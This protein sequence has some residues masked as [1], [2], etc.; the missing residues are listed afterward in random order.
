MPQLILTATGPDRPG[1]VGELTGVLHAANCNILESR[2]VNLRGEFAMIILFDCPADRA[3]KIETELE[4]AA[5]KMGLRA[6]LS[7]QHAQAARISGQTYRLKTYSTD[8]PG[9][10]ARVTNVLR[11]H[12]VNIEELEAKQESAPFAGEP[13]FLTEMV[14]TFPAATDVANLRRDLTETGRAIHCDIDL[15][16]A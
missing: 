15:D 16:P 8:Q 10:V 4:G 14:L 13:L 7:A 12:G 6:A 1:I 11:A 3:G 5:E 9:I 2:M